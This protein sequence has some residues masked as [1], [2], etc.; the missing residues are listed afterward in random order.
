MTGAA[1]P[2][3]CFFE[4]LFNVWLSLQLLPAMGCNFEN[5]LMIFTQF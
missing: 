1:L 4:R 3:F 5:F 2:C